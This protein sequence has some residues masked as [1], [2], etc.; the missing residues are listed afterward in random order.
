MVSI[1]RSWADTLS[2]LESG[3]PVLTPV[4]TRV[5]QVAGQRQGRGQVGRHHQGGEDGQAEQANLVT[6]CP[7]H[8]D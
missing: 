1:K 7:L 6:H 4:L 2:R 3:S 5:A 8:L